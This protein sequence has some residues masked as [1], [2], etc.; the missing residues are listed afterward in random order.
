MDA[1][2]KSGPQFIIVGAAKSGTTS[3]FKYLNQHPEI[4]IPAIK[5]CRF[6]S[7]LPRNQRGWGAERFPNGGIREPRQYLELYE[8]NREQT[9]GDVSN[10]YLYYYH[11]SIENIKKLLGDKVKIIIILRNP[12]DRAYSN[13]LH[14][15]REGWE[16]GSFEKALEFEKA[17]CEQK[18]AWP[19]HYKQVGLYYRQVKAYLENFKDVRVYLFED[20][21]HNLRQ[22]MQDI[23]LFLKVDSR[24]EP[25]I[26]KKY[27]VS[28]FPRSKLVQQLIQNRSRF[29]KLIKPVYE[30]IPKAVRMSINQGIKSLNLKKIPMEPSAR[31][32]LK[33]YFRQDIKQLNSIIANDISHW[34]Q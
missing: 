16:Q 21:N 5:E 25:E 10:D 20:L 19:Y 30:I 18:W 15:V 24:F 1:G 23:F 12:V 34:L 22:L 32:Y 26:S 11:P 7:Q 9:C 29:N 14:H 2:Y 13:F 28:G 3:I 4:F 6:F 8:K 33:E 31:S 27:N 17:R